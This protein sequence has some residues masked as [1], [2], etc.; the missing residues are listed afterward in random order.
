MAQR[1][2]D[3]E[4]APYIE[5]IRRVVE[6]G[7]SQRDLAADLIRR[8]ADAVLQYGTPIRGPY[9]EKVHVST[10]ANGQLVIVQFDAQPVHLSIPVNPTAHGMVDYRSTFHITE[11]IH[12]SSLNKTR[13]D[14]YYDFSTQ[15]PKFS[16]GPR[17]FLSMPRVPLVFGPAASRA[18]GDEPMDGVSL[19]PSNSGPEGTWGD[20]SATG[21]RIRQALAAAI[22]AYRQATT[23][24]A[25]HER[26]GSEGEKR[27]ALR[28]A[29]V[30]TSVNLTAAQSAFNA[31][32]TKKGFPP[33]AGDMDEE[34]D[35]PIEVANA[36]RGTGASSKTFASAPKAPPL[37]SKGSQAYVNYV[38]DVWLTTNINLANKEI[39]KDALRKQA[40]DARRKGPGSLTFIRM[41]EWARSRKYLG[42]TTRRRVRKGTVRRRGTMGRARGGRTTRRASFK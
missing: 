13:H 18:P 12:D 10:A 20:P 3:V 32:E 4:A 11:E 40:D 36:G 29:V 41:E 27:N 5:F 42:G 21:N 15:Q 16:S 2:F 24:L 37:P 19:K 26:D 33:G 31:H 22:D 1:P 8:N 35:S 30:A 38:V 9:V 34:E 6:A 23:A 39:D 17:S 7:V 25:K 14:Q 28:K